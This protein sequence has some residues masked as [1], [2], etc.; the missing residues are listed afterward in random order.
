MTGETRKIEPNEVARATPYA[1][2]ILG[3][4]DTAVQNHEVDPI[5]LLLL[6]F[7]ELMTSRKMDPDTLT[8]LMEQAVA[9]SNE[10][11]AFLHPGNPGGPVS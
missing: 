11:K 10:F 7:G 9:S 4:I 5:L 1:A 6:L 2:S 3:V 8:R